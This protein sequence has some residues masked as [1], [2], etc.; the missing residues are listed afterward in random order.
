[1]ATAEEKY[2][3]LLESLGLDSE[4]G[5]RLAAALG[6]NTTDEAVGRLKVLGDVALREMVDWVLSTRRF[7]TISE[8]D[9]ARVL[10]IFLKIRGEYPTVN[11]LVDELGISSSRAVSLLGRLKYGEGKALARLARETAVEEIERQ[12]AERVADGDGRKAL[13][14]T[15]STYE[16]TEDADFKIM[17]QPQLHGKGQQYAGAESAVF[18]SRGRQGGAVRASEKMWTYIVDVIKEK[19]T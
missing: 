16:E 17:S 7:G 12:L 19:I 11:Q 3:T 15:K 14:L 18:G 8:L 2:T 5:K 13:L 10:A 4:D 9:G 6:A 1:M